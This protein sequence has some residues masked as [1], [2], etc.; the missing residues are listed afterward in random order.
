MSFRIIYG[1]FFTTLCSFTLKNHERQSIMVAMMTLSPIEE[2][3]GKI[4]GKEVVQ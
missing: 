3:G 2:H 1:S 4:P